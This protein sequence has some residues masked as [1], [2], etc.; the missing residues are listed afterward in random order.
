MGVEEARAP[1][2]LASEQVGANECLE[3]LHLIRSGESPVARKKGVEG[4]EELG[5]Q[6]GEQRP[7]LGGVVLKRSAGEHD[8]VLG[9]E[10][11]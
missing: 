6:E 10:G 2:L 4:G 11:G 9:A 5:V 8:G 1:H 7:E 3:L